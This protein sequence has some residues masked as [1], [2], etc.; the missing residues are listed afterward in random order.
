MRGLNDDLIH[1]KGLS[2]ICS[3]IHCLSFHNT[4]PTLVLLYRAKFLLNRRI[5]TLGMAVTTLGR[6]VMENGGGSQS[7]AM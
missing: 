4:S 6:K 5:I 7:A 3:H 1:S 2:D